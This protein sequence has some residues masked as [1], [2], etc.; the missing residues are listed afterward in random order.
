MKIKHILLAIWQL[1]QN[2]LG[3]VLM[4]L[5]KKEIEVNTDIVFVEWKLKRMGISLGNF[6]LLGEY[7]LTEKTYKHE[8]GHTIQS[9]IL[10]PLYLI[11]VG[12]PSIT[13]NI[14]SI[15]IGGKFRKNYYKRW[16]ESWADKLGGV[17]R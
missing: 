6:I 11:V 3:L 14:I 17:V 9:K 13:M 12:L 2:I 5:F 1:P 15:I 4:L 10:G 7:N 8:F 16:P